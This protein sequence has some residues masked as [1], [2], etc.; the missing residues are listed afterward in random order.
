MGEMI[1]MPLFKRGIQVCIMPFLAVF[2][3]LCMYTTVIVYMYN[4]ELSDMLSGYQEALP[5]LMAAVGM[6]GAASDL[7]EWMQIYLYGFIM[8]LF[9]LIFTLVMV[10]KLLLGQ[11]ESGTLANLLATPNSRKKVIC[12]QM[13]SLIL[14]VALLIL[15]VTAVGVVSCEALFP[16]ELDV[17]KYLAL[18]FSTFLLQ[19]S[20]AG[21]AFLAACF[22]SG[23]RFY[24]LVGAGLPV[25]FFFI[26]MA[27][28]MG[29]KLE[30]LR[31]A[32]I[33]SLLPVE[34]ILKEN[35]LFPVQNLALLGIA[36]VLFGLGAWQFCRRD[37]HL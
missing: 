37:L 3:L 17:G 34:G 7:L 21:I 33:Y 13:V 9:P 16:G 35:I 5:E 36:A 22:A 12:T 25:L 1:S 32:T 19:A 27:S 14:G 28:N 2:A 29:E 10:Q 11:I 30:G 15:L 24:Y 23:G 8:L 4:P 20:V 26:Q 18:N 6:T 31:Y